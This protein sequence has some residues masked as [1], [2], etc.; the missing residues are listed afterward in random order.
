MKPNADVRRDVDEMADLR[1]ESV[2][3]LRR[4][5]HFVTAVV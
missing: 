4:R 3:S 2:V 5:R 1:R